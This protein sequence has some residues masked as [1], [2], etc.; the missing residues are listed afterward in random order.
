MLFYLVRVPQTKCKFANLWSEHFFNSHVRY[1]RPAKLNRQV[2]VLLSWVFAGH[3]HNTWYYYRMN[4]NIVAVVTTRPTIYDN[5]LE[6]YVVVVEALAAV[7]CR[8]V[9]SM[10]NYWVSAF[11]LLLTNYRCKKWMIFCSQC[12]SM[13]A[14]S[15]Q[16]N[17]PVFKFRALNIPGSS[18]ARRKI[19]NVKLSNH[20]CQ[21]DRRSCDEIARLDWICFF[22]CMSGPTKKHI[23]GCKSIWKRD[24]SSYAKHITKWV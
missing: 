19:K 17:F 8:Q 22:D 16:M 6:E 15:I 1:F 7:F 18:K 5:S 3:E 10:V 23:V 4:N 14:S 9:K 11:F 12:A 13:N 21:R 2:V 20:Q 24:D